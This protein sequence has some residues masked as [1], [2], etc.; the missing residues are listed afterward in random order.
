MKTLMWL[1]ACLLPA[2]VFGADPDAALLPG[3]WTGT[4]RYYET[5]LQRQSEAPRFDLD[6][7]PDLTVSGTVGQAR[8]VPAR[9]R[10]IGERIDYYLELEGSVASDQKVRGKDHLV[11]L[12]TRLTAESLEADFHLKSGFSFDFTMHPG[13]LQAVRPG[14]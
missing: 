13:E 4:G 3:K 14:P 9:P 5:S 12:V 6:I 8:L 1:M 7:A 10:A 2:A 11:I